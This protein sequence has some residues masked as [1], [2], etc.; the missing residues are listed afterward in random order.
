MLAL[1]LILAA[2]A[3][4]APDETV[5]RIDAVAIPASAVRARLD[6]APGAP[7]AA[8]LQDLLNDAALAIDA[9]RAGYAADPR[10]TAAVDRERRRLAARR[11]IAK[12]LADMPPV[13]D[14]ALRALF[15]GQA[16]GVRI[17]T[18]VV[19]DA[20]EAARVKARLAAGADF[21]VE[22][23]RSLDPAGRDGKA[24]WRTRSQLDGALLQA[25]FSAPLKE[26]AGPVGLG[27]GS[28]VIQVLERTVGTEEE[29]AAKRDGL[30]RFAAD[31]LRGHARQQILAKLRREAGAT[32]DEG[33]LRSTGKRLEATPEEEAHAVARVHG[34]P[35]TYGEILPEIRRL[36]R[37]MEGGHFSGPS[38]KLEVAGQAV[39][40]R[41]MEDAAVAAGLDR[42]GEIEAALAPVERDELVRAYAA[43]LR[44]RAPKP[45]PAEVEAH[46]A[47]NR[48]RLEQ[49]GRRACSH[50]LTRT[51]GQAEMALERVRGGQPFADVAR[52]L[53]ID[54]A[55]AAQGGLLG[56]IPDDRLQALARQE[57]DLAAAIRDAG[58]GRV[59]GPVRSRAGWHLLLCQAHRP[60]ST[61]P[62]AEVAP[63]ITAFLERQHG[64]DAV[65]ARMAAARAG[66]KV[67]IDEAA[68]QRAAARK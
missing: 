67:S 43:D 55:T 14:A 39:D 28:A 9:E 22:A 5:A 61:P 51:R 46:Y 4:G 2:G 66:A 44:A 65:R 30:R 35:I 60:P 49:P 33:F 64:D 23:R 59:A 58:A 36:A 21:A 29:F 10:V 26:F 15:H 7:P 57:P 68:L 56:D 16:D 37:G 40:E 3:A 62:L 27:L 45:T 13:D 19:L 32:V 1:A 24:Q 6:A 48:A 52:D 31:Q 12:A 47:A 18:I 11:W 63:A 38:V 42:G 25:A 41:V 54:G 34:K 53:S 8:V 17:R 20:A 50:L